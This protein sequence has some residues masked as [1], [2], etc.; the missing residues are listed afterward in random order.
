VNSGYEEFRRLP[1][2]IVF[3]WVLKIFFE[4]LY[5][6]M[7]LAADVRNPSG[8]TILTPRFLEDYRLEHALLNSARVPVR[9]GKP[10]P[11]S[12]FVLP[13]QVSSKAHRNFDFVDN[14]HGQVIAIRMSEV[15]V[16]A[17]L[18]DNQTQEGMFR[19]WFARVADRVRLHPIQFREIAAKIVDKRQTMTLTP[20]FMTVWPENRSGLQVVP[21]PPGGLSGGAAFR[22]W[23]QRE[24]AVLL[25]VFIRDFSGQSLDEL[26]EVPN[27][28][29][30]FLRN[31]RRYVN[32]PIDGDVIDAAMQK[33]L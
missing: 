19:R 2:G 28:V 4:T 29:M 6:E 31:G 11:W 9:V 10:L 8:G 5:L 14:L 15:A 20:Q 17:V 22:Q 3:Q 12:I 26:Y 16:F 32:S 24:F 18:L 25:Q 1:R 7:R 21:F 33:A 30:T 13:A 27:R 23:N